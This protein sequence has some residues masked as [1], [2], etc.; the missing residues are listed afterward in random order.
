MAGRLSEE[1]VVQSLDTGWQSLVWKSK[2][3]S[4]NI[5]LSPSVDFTAILDAKDP[6][7]AAQAVPRRDM[8]LALVTGGSEV[9]LDILPL[10]SSEQLVT[11][12]DNE[13]WH[14]GQ[15]A[16]HQAIR[17]LDLYKNMDPEFLYQR[18]R[19]LDEEY[20]VGFL[21]PYIDMVD[22]ESFEKLPHDEQD[23]FTAMPCNTLW[24]RVKSG[25]EKIQEFVSSLI[26][27]S[28][29][30]DAAYIYTLLGM[31]AMLPPNEQEALL[32]QFRDAR[33]EEDGFVTTEES[34][35]L[36]G[37]FDGEALYS[38]WKA[39]KSDCSSD[40]SVTGDAGV[41]FLDAVM[42]VA[43]STGRADQVAVD[44]VMRGFGYL[45]NAVSGACHVE[46]DDI[47]GLSSLLSQ[48]RHTVS[49]GLEVLSSGDVTKALEIL[50]TEYPKVVFQ[51]A[52]STVNSIRAE[53]ISGLMALSPA[54]ASKLES[55]WKSGKFGSAL[56]LIDRDFLDTLG[57][58]SAEVLKGL[59]NR[60]PLVKEEVSSLEGVERVV[61]R[62]LATTEDYSAL[63]SDVRKY[64]S[65]NSG[66][67]LQ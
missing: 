47:H 13:A 29:S 40:L 44:N 2:Y 24:W 60:F 53:A 37:E 1:A 54:N 67:T 45:A 19:E 31:A 9:A 15:L 30:E 16:I 32:R 27:S 34:R 42:S 63:L 28:I 18:F 6:A 52:I 22:E 17:W 49:F 58:D 66:G 46:P 61:F 38:K 4:K 35:A 11:I 14:D 59:F 36:F 3:S 39:V 8:Y 43:L 57:F 55:L 26:Q 65:F 33:L 62:P 20:Q 48:V 12:M 7:E 25:D 5:S 51:F 64:L 21:N 23:K 41:L 10:L 50:F 56:W